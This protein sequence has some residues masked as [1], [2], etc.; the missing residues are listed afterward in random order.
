MREKGLE[1]LEWRVRANTAFITRQM[2]LCTAMIISCLVCFAQFNP[3]AFSGCL[4]IYFLSLYQVD[5]SDIAYKKRLEK[6]GKYEQ[7]DVTW[8]DVLCLNKKPKDKSV[9]NGRGRDT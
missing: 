3:L 2:F 8:K 4:I 5:K 6:I 1:R 7:V 9:K